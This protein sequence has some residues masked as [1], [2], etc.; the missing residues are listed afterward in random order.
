MRRSLLAGLLIIVLIVSAG[1][2]LYATDESEPPTLTVENQDNTTYF[3]T[4]YAFSDPSDVAFRATTDNQSRRIIGKPKIYGGYRNLTAIKEERSSRFS[5]SPRSNITREIAVWNSS[6]ILVYIVETTDGN[7]SVLF[8]E[9]VNC[10]RG[11]Q[12]HRL[13]ITD[14]DLEQGSFTCSSSLL[15]QFTR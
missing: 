4:A 15:D 14:G 9:V 12:E 7:E 11:G 2:V 5:V 8:G 13:S 1:Y 10:E 6:V 3:I